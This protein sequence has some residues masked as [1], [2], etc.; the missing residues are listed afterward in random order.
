MAS[1]RQHG[2]GT[3][4]QRKGR[5]GAAVPLP[6]DGDGRRRRLYRLVPPERPNTE[7][8]AHRLR[9]RL[10]KEVAAGLHDPPPAA[11]QEVPTIATWLPRWYEHVAP[12]LAPATRASYGYSI[13]RHLVPALGK[14][15][16]DE[17]TAAHVAAFVADQRA[18][19]KPRTVV[20]RLRLLRM[21]LR[22]A[23]DWDIIGRN[24]ATRVRGPRID[25]EQRPT[26]TI[27]QARALLAATAGTRM[28][29]MLTL[30]LLG[31][32]K[33]E[34]RGLRWE[35]VDLDARRLSVRV[36]ARDGE[37]GQRVKTPTSRRTIPLAAEHVRTL[38][39]HRDRERMARRAAGDRW[40][41]HG[42]VI[43]GKAGKPIS[44]HAVDYQWWKLR[45]AHQLDHIHWHDLRHTA[46]S[47]LAE[48][49]A[50]P[51]V[52]AAI[53]GHAGLAMTAHYTHASASA[54]IAATDA[55]GA[56]LGG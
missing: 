39:A 5:W 52:I 41:E 48:Q 21:A 49:G 43:T 9:L 33:G 24:V 12:D 20:L 30:A 19:Y 32:R 10:V 3:V 8:E 31:L 15:R 7:D 36:Q 28:E 55:L 35:D 34:M 44:T 22:I 26:L 51:T 25:N 6:P 29:A 11:P 50:H 1:R 40:Q 27:D 2:E 13:E 45:T 17:L 47:L 23:M 56:S 53:L 4:F 14:H 37:T 42:L 18:R 38:T 54:I 46:A 16:L